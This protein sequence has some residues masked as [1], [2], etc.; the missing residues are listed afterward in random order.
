MYQVKKRDGKIV[1]FDLNKIKEAIR[2]AFESSN[3]N[4][5]DDVLTTLALKVV[6]DFGKKIHDDLIGVEDIQDSVEKILIESGFSDVAK[7]Y[8]L[9]RR[10]HQ[11]IREFNSGVFSYKDIIDSYMDDTNDYYRNY[12]V[13]GFI[14]SNS[15]NVTSNYLINEL[16]D[17][18]IKS[19]YEDGYLYLHDLQMMIGHS[20]GWDFKSLVKEDDDIDLYLQQFI[21]Q[22]R[23]IGG[24]WSG[25]QSVFGFFAGLN[26]YVNDHQIDEDRLRHALKLMVNNINASGYRSGALAMDLIYDL[27]QESGLKVFKYLIEEMIDGDCSY[28][29]IAVKYGK[30]IP[31][32]DELKDLIYRFT[33]KYGSPIFECKIEKT[34][35]SDPRNDYKRINYRRAYSLGSDISS[36]S[37]ALASLNLVKIAAT[38]SDEEEFFEKIDYYFNLACR[39]L[40][41]RRNVSQML[42]KENLYPYSRRHL[43]NLNKYFLTIGLVGIDTMCLN[44]PFLDGP[45]KEKKSLDFVLEL[46][47]HI[48]ELM[49]R[50]QKESKCLIALLP[51]VNQRVYELLEQNDSDLNVESLDGRYRSVDNFDDQGLDLFEIL[52]IKKKI[53]EYFN[54]SN[55]ITIDYSAKDLDPEALAL[56]IDK[57]CLYNFHA[58]KVNAKED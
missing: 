12:S 43:R 29:S 55:V 54:T 53:D 30:K 25:H 45:L 44:L 3:K 6:S 38:S 19:A 42:F 35:N 18:D 47:R 8:I 36:G 5:H 26:E 34:V 20:S 48:N 4:T 21:D 40:L 28:P 49:I 31:W 10:Q 7:A 50:Q 9:Y 57:S 39:E 23:Q 51:L 37:L 56:L 33:L 1:E 11:N 24:E 22:L 17:N 41:T 46:L 13:N 16:F 27:E 32:D 2:K 14:F 15:Y 58:F 52:D